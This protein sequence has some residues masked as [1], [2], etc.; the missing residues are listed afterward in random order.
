LDGHVEEGSG[1]HDRIEGTGRH[2][3]EI[4]GIRL[5]QL[6]VPELR[7]LDGNPRLLKHARRKID[8][9]NLSL[10]A[11]PRRR[12]YRSEPSANPGIQYPIGT[13]NC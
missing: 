10:R 1:T 3:A 5:A 8:A 11:N 4:T 7:S 13:A 9:D 2:V 12:R 6:H